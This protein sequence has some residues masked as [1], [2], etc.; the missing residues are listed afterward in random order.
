M[1]RIGDVERAAATSRVAD[2]YHEATVEDN[3]VP[4]DNGGQVLHSDIFV[5]RGDIVARLENVGM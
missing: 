2:V 5:A 3:G 4:P 1:H